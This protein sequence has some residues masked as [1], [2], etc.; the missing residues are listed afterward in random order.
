MTV[1]DK[2]YI[3]N[4]K[5]IADLY[6]ALTS[7]R[8]ETPTRPFRFDRD[9]FLAAAAMGAREGLFRQIVKRKE[10]FSW[11]T[12]LNDE[13]ALPVLQAIALWHTKDPEVLVDDDQ[14]A[15]IA[16]GFANGGIEA[17]A[18]RLSNAGID[19]LQEAAVLL[20]EERS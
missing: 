8:G 9:V 7:E 14:V 11:G 2:I 13:N 6:E 10:K 12:L 19:E 3:E 18:R 5:K 16:E 4:D 1:R 20:G 15:A 17:L